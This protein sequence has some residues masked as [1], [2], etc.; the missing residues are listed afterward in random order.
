MNKLDALVFV[1]NTRYFVENGAHTVRITGEIC[2]RPQL[3]ELLYHLLAFPGYFGFNWD[4]LSDCLRDFHWIDEKIIVI[5]HD[6]LPNI[7]VAELKIYLDILC[8]A[9]IDWKPGEAHSLKVVFNSKDIVRIETTIY[10]QPVNP[11]T[12][13]PGTQTET[14]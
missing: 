11:A 4:A 7:P 1:P 6:E 8:D 9:V 13:K 10:G 5:V 2:T 14:H 12:G 3:F